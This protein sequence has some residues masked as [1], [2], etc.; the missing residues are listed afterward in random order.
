VSALPLL[1]VA[2]NGARRNKTDHPDLPI[3]IAELVHEAKACHAAGADGI[4]IHVRDAQGAHTL[5]IGLY[6]EALQELAIAV[7]AMARQITTEAVG[8]YSP[9]QQREVVEAILPESVSI[10]IAEMQRDTERPR[11]D[12]FYKQCVHS[13]IAVQHIVYQPEDLS[14]VIDL[15]RRAELPM[16][17]L[18]LMFVLGRYTKN[19]QS[20]PKSIQ[21]YLQT[22]I[23][24]D[25]DPVEV[26]WAICA[27]GQQESACLRAAHQAG[28]KL[29]VGFENSLWHADGSVAKNNAARVA[30]IVT[31]CDLA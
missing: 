1:M 15:V 16:V 28:G 7:P 19:Q 29:R 11:V 5:D 21:P 6:K 10:A 12:N 22:L 18:Q 31:Q 2:P 17:G 3:T 13:G 26:D 20:D 24:A 25:V 14:A 23:N 8:L 27:F 4:H 9:A 30:E